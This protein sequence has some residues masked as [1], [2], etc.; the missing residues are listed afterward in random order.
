MAR[1]C[2]FELFKEEKDVTEAEWRDYFLTARVPDN[3]VYKTLEKRAEPTQ[4]KGGNKSA[5]QLNPGKRDFGRSRNDSKAQRADAHQQ[6]KSDQNSKQKS[7]RVK[8]PKKCFKCGDPTHGVF[9]CP[10]IASP[11]EAKEIYE[12]TTGKKVLKPILAV[13]P[14]DSKLA[15]QPSTDILETEITPDSAAEVSIVTKIY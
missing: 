15:T 1:I 3:T 12:P 11:L 13:A 10:D 6:K 8:L 14:V 7:S 5:H 4:P 2:G 9:Q